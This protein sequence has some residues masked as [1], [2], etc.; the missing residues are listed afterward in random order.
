[1]PTCSA[2][3]CRVGGQRSGEPEC[4]KVP[5]KSF[6]KDPFLRKKWLAQINVKCWE[7]K[8]NSRICFLHFEEV[9]FYFI[10][11]KYPW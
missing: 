1:M 2:P 3:Y 11:V 10:L 6:P 5:S 9:R 4:P 7:P 8:P